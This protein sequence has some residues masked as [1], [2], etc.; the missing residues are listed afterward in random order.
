ML[1]QAKGL[2]TSWEPI[3]DDS[4]IIHLINNDLMSS[5][6]EICPM[7]SQVYSYGHISLRIKQP[8]LETLGFLLKKIG[9]DWQFYEKN[10]NLVHRNRVRSIVAPKCNNQMFRW[11][12]CIW[13]SYCTWKCNVHGNRT[14]HF[15]FKC[16]FYS[17]LLL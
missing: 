9:I 1:I 4:L 6:N 7:R 5:F 8:I 14:V 12:E 10:V 13:Q 2:A 11:T 15:L 3:T 16:F 17:R